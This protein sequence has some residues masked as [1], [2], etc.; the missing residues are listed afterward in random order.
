MNAGVA[1]AALLRWAPEPARAAPWSLLIEAVGAGALVDGDV[2]ELRDQLARG[3]DLVL[4][5]IGFAFR[6]GGLQVSLHDRGAACS[7][8]SMIAALARVLDR[9]E[10][11][12]AVLLGLDSDAFARSLDGLAAGVEVIETAIRAA[13]DGHVSVQASELTAGIEMIAQARPA[14]VAGEEGIDWAINGELALVD[15]LLIALQRPGA[16]ARAGRSVVFEHEEHDGTRRIALMAGLHGA[17][18]IRHALEDG[19]AIPDDARLA[20]Q[21]AQLHLGAAAYGPRFAAYLDRYLQLLAALD[22]T[23]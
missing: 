6:G 17:A 7:P 1:I 18:L 5:D 20:P 3:H 8:G 12:R 19:A 2:D 11:A 4:D 15:G 14:L 13:A 10:R 22:G 23:R 21:A 9:A 16:D